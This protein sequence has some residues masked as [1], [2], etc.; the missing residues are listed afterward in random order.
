MNNEQTHNH[1]ENCECGCHR[2]HHHHDEHHH[3]EYHHNEHPRVNPAEQQSF[4]TIKTHDTSLVGSFQFGLDVSF[5]EAETI[6]DALLKQ[7]AREVVALE[8]IIGHIK[9]FLRSEASS[10]MISIT[11]DESDKHYSRATKCHVEGVVIVFGILPLQ[12]ETI[13]K[14]AFGR[15][16]G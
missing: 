5:D 4:V 15:Y 16:L 11:E 3:S 6:L 13:L 2:E 9:A 7:V 14:N 10:C 1:D 8:G 12:L